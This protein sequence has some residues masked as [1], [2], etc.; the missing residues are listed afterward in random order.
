MRFEVS[1]FGDQQV[2][3]EI[4]RV[5]KR[6]A[7]SRPLWPS[8]VDLMESRI[9]LNFRTQGKFASGGW[10]PLKPATILRR[11]LKGQVPIRI[12]TATGALR[13]ALTTSSAAGAKRKMKKKELQF[14][15]QGAVNYGAHHQFG[16]PAAKLPM[17]KPVEFTE[18]TRKE[19]VKRMQRF[20]MTGE[21]LG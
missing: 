10:Q 15:T 5:G 12:L 11:K 7:D 8:I 13:E 1:V 9:E 4:L 6:P 17:R 14:G 20:V 21:V 18:A 16:A 2:S 19:L 3:R